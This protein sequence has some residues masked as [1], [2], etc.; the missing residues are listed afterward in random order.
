MNAKDYIYLC[1][2][3]SSSKG[4]CFCY[5]LYGSMQ[6]RLYF[7][8][9]TY[10]DPIDAIKG[11]TVVLKAFSSKCTYIHS[12]QY[13]LINRIPYNVQSSRWTTSVI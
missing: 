5:T 11:V 12:V 9:P 7:S 4:V 1:L 8:D 13:N 3:F 6:Y 10:Q 2:N